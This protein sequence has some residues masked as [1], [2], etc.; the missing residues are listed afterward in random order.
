MPVAELDKA[1]RSVKSR[2]I[3][4]VKL[5]DV[6]EGDRIAE[7]KKSVAYSLVLRAEDR[8]LT[9]DECSDVVG[10]VIKALSAIG[11]ELRA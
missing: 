3:E 10:K 5:F 11:A 9:D 8:T 1:I 2:I 4:D 7:N 6:Y